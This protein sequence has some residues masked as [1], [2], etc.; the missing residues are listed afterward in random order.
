MSEEKV[1]LPAILN[2]VWRPVDLALPAFANDENTTLYG[3]L[4]G[5]SRVLTALIDE[6]AGL[7]ARTVAMERHKDAVQQELRHA[8]DL[9]DAKRRD[10][11]AEAHM[12]TLVERD[13][14]RMQAKARA[15]AAR[16]QELEDR[17]QAGQTALLRQHARLAELQK[18]RQWIEDERA[19]W[20]LAA[21]QKADD[22]FTLQKY[23]AIDDRRTGEIGLSLR[24]QRDV[25]ADL[26]RALRD[27]VDR[28]LAS[29]AA[30]DKAAEVFAR[31]Q[32][33]RRRA[34]AQFQGAVSVLETRDYEESV[35]RER[36]AR[37]E[38][39]LQGLRA[40]DR[41]ARAELE[42]AGRQRGRAETDLE[43]AERDATNA[44]AAAARVEHELDTLSSDVLVLR[45]A[46]AATQ[47]D[48]ARRARTVDAG[49]ATLALRTRDLA[50]LEARLALLADARERLDSKTAS[51]EE[52]AAELNGV[53]DR[54]QQEHAARQAAAEAAQRALQAAGVRLQELKHEEGGVRS[55]IGG[56]QT[57][58]RGLEARVAAMEAQIQ[59]QR[60]HIYNADFQVQALTRRLSVVRGD[61]SY[62]ESLVLKRNIAVMT[63]Q[64]ESEL[65]AGTLVRQQT[66]S[67]VSEIGRVKRSLDD[68]VA[69]RARL[70]TEVRELVLTTDTSGQHRRALDA[71]RGEELLALDSL[72]MQLE[73]LMAQYAARSAVVFGLTNRGEQQRLGA[74]QRLQEAESVRAL[75]AQET[76]LVDQDLSAT[77]L[78]VKRRRIHIEKLAA[79]CAVLADRVSAAA[80]A[81]SGKGPADADPRTAQ[82]DA[83][84]SLGRRRADVQRRFDE[85]AA[86][87]KKAEAE[88]CGLKQ[89][90]DALRA[91][92]AAIR[93]GVRPVSTGGAELQT[94][95]ALVKELSGAESEALYMGTSI[96]K[97]SREVESLEA[98][99][100]ELR[101]HV[102][103][104]AADLH[105]AEF[106]TL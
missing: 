53:V 35:L 99:N 52:R 51:A 45:G 3:E 32:A 5:E 29:Q 74:Q 27:E 103:E 100:R 11:E 7:E 79:R 93:K 78:E 43:H 13:L 104:L 10:A 14:G 76:R 66:G 26:D 56:L 42:D 1:D 46:L 70:D 22:A 41:R 58:I 54:A 44:Q 98:H 94:L 36:V 69:R 9:C 77:R 48:A 81:V 17:R 89:A 61:H 24:R 59:Q 101:Q 16:R 55:D 96:R 57:G 6:L 19:E 87:L 65:R 23:Q 39:D 49:A 60:R 105:D 25:V 20:H 83:I 2:N 28:T 92:N 68:V 62:E 102:D 21:E 8:Q 86:L 85:S 73:R 12:A 47:R 67:V 88:V 90:L 4:R 38:L 40:T 72:R 50:R 30:L 106:G 37:A 18:E 71:R 80:A 34:L 95:K 31:R 15:C 97:A 63:A 84:I 91:S 33:E 64:H 75:L 82:S